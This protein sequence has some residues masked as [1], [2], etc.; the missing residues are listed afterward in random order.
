MYRGQRTTCSSLLL[1]SE[2]PGSNSG[3]LARWPVPLA[4]E[5]SCHPFLEFIELTLNVLEV[6]NGPNSRATPKEF[7]AECWSRKSSLQQEYGR[8]PSLHVPYMILDSLPPW[9]HLFNPLH[10]EPGNPAKLLQFHWCSYHLPLAS[11]AAS[12]RDCV[13]RNIN[14]WYRGSKRPVLPSFC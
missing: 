4:S 9:L 10:T 3:H 13:N 2:F 5:P 8:T 12:S 14:E 1:P 6:S 7:S 11:R